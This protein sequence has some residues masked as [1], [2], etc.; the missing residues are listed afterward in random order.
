MKRLILSM[1]GFFLMTTVAFAGHPLVTDDTG[2]Q[3]TGRGQ[4]EFG[5]SF[6]KD[7]DEADEMTTFKAEGGD[8]AVGVTIGLLDSLDIVMG[9]PYV[10]YSL[11]ENDSRIGRESGISDIS[12]DVK[13][14]FFEK[15]GWSL[16]LK[17]GLSLPTGDEDRGLGA[18]RTSYR[19]FLIGTKE[20]ESVAFH[21]N[22]GYI[23][24]ENNFEERQDIWHVSV[25]AEV[26]VIKDLKLMANA[27]MERN[28]DP[29]SDN[30]PAFALGGISYDVSEKVT[31]DAGLKY[32]LT[33][34]ETD[35]TVL[36]GLTIRVK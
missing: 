4:V 20:F 28:P 22:G 33:S 34:T 7:K 5:L 12:F 8:M 6:F 31:L 24:N 16:A 35:W 32:G 2:T 10:W 21:V 23:R 11:E 19:L 15:N 30:H 1:A 27:G 18:G 36:T 9:V 3:G 14:R 25:A 17:P 29:S 26:E 13:W